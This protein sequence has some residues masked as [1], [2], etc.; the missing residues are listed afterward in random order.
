MLPAGESAKGDLSY[1]FSSQIFDPFLI[2]CIRPK[3]TILS[4]K[5]IQWF[6]RYRWK[7]KSPE[8]STNEIQPL[9]IFAYSVC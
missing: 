7:N 3:Y 5:H 8:L 4:H 9:A 1:D 2:Q 6:M